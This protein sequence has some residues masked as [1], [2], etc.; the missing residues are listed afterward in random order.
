M[1]VCL[2]PARNA[3]R[4]IASTVSLTAI[5]SV[6]GTVSL[7]AHAQ[8]QDL[9]L[10]ILNGKT[11]RPVTNTHVTLWRDM[12][13]TPLS[14]EAAAQVTTDGEGYAAVPANDSEFIVVYTDGRQPCSTTFKRTY[15]LTDVRM[16]G[17]VSENSCNKHIHT[18]A[19]Q[20]TLVVFVRELTLYERLRH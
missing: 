17:L 7:A 5:A 8:T 2:E 1:H 13:H 11:G 6:I 14:R 20:G 9:R 3:R 4:R 12:N 10:Q 18:Y 15:S 16:H 19:E